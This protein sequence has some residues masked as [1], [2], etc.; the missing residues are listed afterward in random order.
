MQANW[1]QL[2]VY[3]QYVSVCTSWDQLAD[4]DLSV[5][6]ATDAGNIRNVFAAMKERVFH[7]TL[8]GTDYL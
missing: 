6:Q 3:P 4:D 1:A 2:S 7:N 5:T 8:K